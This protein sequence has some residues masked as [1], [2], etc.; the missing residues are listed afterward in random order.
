MYF[1]GDGLFVAVE[2]SIGLG[3]D[4]LFEVGEALIQKEYEE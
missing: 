3:E 2:L 1:V 4:C